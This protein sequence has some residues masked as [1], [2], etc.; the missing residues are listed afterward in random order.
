MTTSHCGLVA[1]F[2]SFDLL[3]EEMKRTLGA[4]FPGDVE[5]VK[6]SLI[7]SWKGK[8]ETIKKAS[9]T[10]SETRI[11]DLVTAG[12]ASKDVKKKVS[13]AVGDLFKDRRGRAHSCCVMQPLR[14][15]AAL[16]LTALVPDR[17][18]NRCSHC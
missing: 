13:D 5:T 11:E 6:K 3:I 9:E 4:E 14:W 7:E 17:C 12:D 15:L 18:C 16:E 10:L 8:D 1:V 2:G